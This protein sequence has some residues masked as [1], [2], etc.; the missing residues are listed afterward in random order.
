MKDS[1][2]TTALLYEPW[3][4]G[5]EASRHQSS[6][7]KLAY[8]VV[9]LKYNVDTATTQL[10]T[11]E[12]NTRMV[13]LQSS[14]E[15][16][17]IRFLTWHPGQVDGKVDKV[18]KT[19]DTITGSVD[20]LDSKN[21]TVSTKFDPFTVKIG[22][23]AS[24]I[25][26]TQSTL[27]LLV[28]RLDQ[29]SSVKEAKAVE[30][31]TAPPAKPQ[32][33]RPSHPRKPFPKEEPE[34]LSFLGSNLEAKI[35]S[36]DLSD[37]DQESKR[38]IYDKINSSKPKRTTG[39]APEWASW[40]YAYKDLLTDNEYCNMRY[41]IAWY[42]LKKAIPVQYTLGWKAKGPISKQAAALERH[43]NQY[44]EDKEEWN[45]HHYK[46]T[47]DLFE[48]QRDLSATKRYIKKL[49]QDYGYRDKY[50]LYKKMM[51]L[52]SEPTLL[53]GTRNVNVE[54][55]WGVALLFDDEHL[56]DENGKKLDCVIISRD[57]VLDKLDLFAHQ[58][59]YMRRY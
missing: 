42:F 35:K 15:S 54:V 17:G 6:I 27:E 19:I 45:D 7:D 18:T 31:A 28:L 16:G 33:Q 2:D 43:L 10:G 12:K 41:N 11:L 25:D 52:C 53:R 23:L 30:K 29:V 32:S 22:T 4:T 37:Y 39:N 44:D 13:G 24:D 48:S 8:D 1:T 50:F 3:L 14:Y 58:T 55:K 51:R 38:K 9:K 40:F 5:Y 49:Y 34:E 59:R 57:Y 20:K 21:E 47:L 46:I 56:N 26:T 36:G